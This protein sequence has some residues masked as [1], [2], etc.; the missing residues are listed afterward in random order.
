MTRNMR[1]FDI[2]NSGSCCQV[3][4]SVR[5]LSCEYEPSFNQRL[6]AVTCDGKLIL[7]AWYRCVDFRKV[8]VDRVH[9]SDTYKMPLSCVKKAVECIAKHH[10]ASFSEVAGG[11]IYVVLPITQLAAVS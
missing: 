1:Y 4:P 7:L 2:G 10:D 9:V 3:I 8:V 6:F 11:H 5:Y